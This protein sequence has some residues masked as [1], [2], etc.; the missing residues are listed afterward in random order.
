MTH[1]PRVW[2]L[3]GMGA[4]SRIFRT[5]DFPWDA[6][7]LEWIEPVQGESLSSYADRLLEPFPIHEK[8]LLFG[9]SLG[10][11]IAQDW[12]SRNKVQRVVILSSLHHEAN[13]RPLF[14]ALSKTGVLN[15]APQGTV[16]RLIFFLTR[17]NSLPSRELDLILE[18]MEQFSCEYYRWVLKA[19]LNWERPQPLCEVD[20]IQGEWDPVF[21][22]FEASQGRFWTLTRATHLSFKT[23][24]KEISKL[25]KEKVDPV[26]G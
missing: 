8:D 13:I 20:A 11:I 23:H 4:D 2:V 17:L 15:W 19:V 7:Y 9:Y 12:A 5:L 1:K 25:L 14:R 22:A 10:G 26:L 21:P 24:S 3:P 18:M 6:T 16:L